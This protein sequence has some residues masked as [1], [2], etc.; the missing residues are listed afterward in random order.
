MLKKVMI[1]ITSRH[2][3]VSDAL[4]DVMF[5]ENA[6]DEDEISEAS[7]TEDFPDDEPIEITVEGRLRVTQEGLCTLSYHETE[8]SGM[9]GSKTT[10][11]FD[12]ANPS[13]VTMMRSGAANTA[14]VF[15]PNS[16]NICVY[17]T[18]YMPFELCVHTKE[19]DNRLLDEGYLLLDYIIEFRGA[20]A[21][22]NHFL[23]TLTDTPDRPISLS[24]H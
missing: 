4:F 18:P 9:E 23:L 22:H 15:E 19:V 7:A 5:G 14:L 3:E 8:M 17:N 20:K 10:V 21:E 24:K 16:R 1:Y 12:K 6:R 11:T 13:L 2:T